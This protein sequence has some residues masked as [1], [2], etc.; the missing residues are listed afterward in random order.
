[1][2]V[3]VHKGCEKTYTEEENND[4]ACLYHPSSPIF[5]EGL[6]GWQCCSPRVISF[7]DFLAIPGCT[8]GRHS[9]QQPEAVATTKPQE[10]T[11]KY[12]VAATPTATRIEN[13]VEIYGN[14]PS[15][16]SIGKEFESLAVSSSSLSSGANQI[17][18]KPVNEKTPEE[19]DLSVPVSPGTKCKRGGCSK[20]FIDESTSRA[21][22]GTEAEC[23]YHPGS[24]VFHEGSKGWSCCS[25]KVLEFDEFLKI[26]GCKTGKHL[27]V[28]SK[29]E[30][31]QAGEAVQCRHDWYQ[32]PTSIIMSIYA[33]KVDKEKSSISFRSEEVE[34]NLKMFDGKRFCEVIPLEYCVDPENSTF[35]ILSTKVELNMKK[36]SNKSSISGR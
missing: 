32:T 31:T 7:D 18:K 10:D 1:M 4:T 13:G 14:G 35:E 28:G 21:E 26:R 24:P 16:S 5:H 33:K 27:F 17:M 11:S 6:K 9:D 8:R 29:K 36:A 23:V 19:D 34:A 2:P 22:G 15:V 25:R 20:T 30:D 3:C 12:S